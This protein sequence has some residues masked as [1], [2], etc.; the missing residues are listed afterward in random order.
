[1]SMTF[2]SEANHGDTL[3]LDNMVV[4]SFLLH[5]LILSIIFF[6]ISAKPAMDIWTIVHCR[7][8]EFPLKLR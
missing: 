3:S 8:R 2:L 1:M 4:L 7:S 5:A 6:P